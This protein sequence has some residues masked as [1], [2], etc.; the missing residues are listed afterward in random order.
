DTE[1]ILKYESDESIKRIER[2]QRL[3]LSILE[4]NEILDLNRCKN[5]QIPHT[6][7][8]VNIG[9]IDDGINSNFPSIPIISRYNSKGYEFKKDLDSQITHGTIMASIIGNQFKDLKNNS[10]GIAPGVKIFDFDISN[11]KKEYYFSCILEIFDLIINQNI[12]IDILLISLTT[13]YP[14]DGIDILSLACNTFVDKGILIVCPTGNY[15]PSVNTIGSP[16]AA[17]KVISFG[18][19]TKDLD[20][21]HFS[22]R[23]PTIDNRLKPDFCLPGS[24]IKI[25]LSNDLRMKIKG[26]SI[27]AAIGVGLI[28]LIKEYI[29]KASFD[30]IYELL[31]NSS[32][33]LNLD[34][35]SQGYGMP[36]IISIIKDQD[37]IQEKILPYKYLVKKSIKI[38]VEFA[39]IFI[40]LFY[41]IY[42]FR[43]T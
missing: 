10:I 39:I 36:D 43:I 19:L 7:R 26:T 5:S 25:P 4:I 13:Q 28:A 11:S 27:T 29:P 12:Q 14:S 8:N 24:E 1:L 32:R 3:F 42:F 20:I 18:S 16:S 15:G 22:G 21:A 41:L 35:F 9:I 23:G 40:V 31:K 34:K 17:K 38:T 37:L 6:G 33:D 2:D 30:E